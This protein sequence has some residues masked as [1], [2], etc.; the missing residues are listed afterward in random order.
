VLTIFLPYEFVF[1]SHLM[2]T[3]LGFTTDLN[4]ALQKNNQDIVNAVELISLT[5]LQIVSIAGG[6]WVGGFP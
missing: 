6:C 4:H 3:V 2:Q 1:M 5:K